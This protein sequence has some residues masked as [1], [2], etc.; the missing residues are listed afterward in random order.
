MRAVLLAAGRGRRLGLEGPKCLLEIAGRSLLSRH[1]SHLE[2]AGV[3]A[4]TIVSGHAR[5]LLEDE[6]RRDLDARAAAGAPLRLDVELLFNERFERGS[7]VSLHCAFD[8]LGEGGL[9]MDADV[10]YPTDLLR[11]LVSSPQASCALLDGRSE[12]QGEEMM[13][14]VENGRLRRIAR[15]VGEGWDLVGESVGF[16]KI[17]A[18]DATV[19]ARVLDA[20]VAAERLDQEH[21]D[22]LDKALPELAF[23]IERVD[24][25]AWTEIDFPEDVARAEALSFEI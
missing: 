10:M 21:E 5:E 16:F 19:L 17:S 4:L 12:E 11:R 6:V 14:G 15:R 18:A 8:R 25:L 13:L 3:T 24:D 1:L 2:A 23:G 9:W 20:E 22:G 7:L